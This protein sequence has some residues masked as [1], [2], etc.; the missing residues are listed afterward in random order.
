MAVDP[1][2]SPPSINKTYDPPTTAVDNEPPTDPYG[3]Y[4]AIKSINA[5]GVRVTGTDPNIKGQAD[6]DDDGDPNGPGA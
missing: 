3:A 1:N 5:G 2:A 4:A 6:R